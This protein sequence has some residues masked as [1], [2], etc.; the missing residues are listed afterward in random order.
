M[1]VGHI[2]DAYGPGGTDMRQWLGLWAGSDR[3]RWL[4]QVSLALEEAQTALQRLGI[5]ASDSPAILDLYLQIEATRLTVRAL[6][7]RTPAPHAD[8]TGP[9]WTEPSPWAVRA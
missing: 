6:Q 9:I 8:R 1:P 7:S 4:A 5:G 3:A 2:R